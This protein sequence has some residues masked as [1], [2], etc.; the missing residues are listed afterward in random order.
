MFNFS[1]PYETVLRT[2]RFSYAL[3][4][5]DLGI[6]GSVFGLRSMDPP[7]PDGPAWF[8]T[9]VFRMNDL[10]DYFDAHIEQ[11]LGGAT[12]ESDWL[13]YAPGKLRVKALSG[14]AGPPPAGRFGLKL[15][16]QPFGNSLFK[17]RIEYECDVEIAECRAFCRRLRAFSAACA[18]ALFC[19]YFPG[20]TPSD[21]D[22]EMK[23]RYVRHTQNDFWS[24][25]QYEERRVWALA[26]FYRRDRSEEEKWRRA[27][28]KIAEGKDAEVP[29]LPP[30]MIP[31]A[32]FIGEGALP[33]IEI[34]KPERFT[35]SGEYWRAWPSPEQD[36]AIREWSRKERKER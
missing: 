30:P 26:R 23:R 22:E 15:Q 13:R 32:E 34:E 3:Q 28:R 12:H 7:S 14:T 31:A 35:W 29:A 10:A 27:L 33:R 17:K 4:F 19:R 36:Q 11:L 6:D 18:V 21:L 20:K 24:P 2:N 1:C 5:M 8:S 9:S 16:L 25:R